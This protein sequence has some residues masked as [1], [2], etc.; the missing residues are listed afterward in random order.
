[1]DTDIND[2]FDSITCKEELISK[3]GFD[4][5]FKVGENSGL[6]EGYHLGYHQ[7][8]V[9]GKEIGHY[10]GFAEV[11]LEN[12]HLPSKLK[13]SLFKLCSISKN[14]PR[15][16]N[17]DADFDKL[18]ENIRSLYKLSCSLAGIQPMFRANTSKLNY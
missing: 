11:L 14:F 1:M 16:N 18:L 7:G 9:I 10:I 4:E 17:Q 13:T 15:E 3:R 6:K 2:V 12:K 8:A 5:G